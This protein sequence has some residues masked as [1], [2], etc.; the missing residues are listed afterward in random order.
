MNVG[1]LNN[2]VVQ[3]CE[4]QQSQSFSVH[5]LK[6]KKILHDTLNLRVV[7]PRHFCDLCEEND[8]HLNDLLVVILLILHDVVHQEVLYAQFFSDWNLCPMRS[9]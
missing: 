1:H 8:H 3:G 4:R 9:E 2:H 5:F 7:K 6:I